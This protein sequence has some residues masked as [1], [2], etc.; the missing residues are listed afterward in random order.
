MGSDPQEAENDL[1]HSQGI[2]VSPTPWAYFP[3]IQ[4]PR[5]DALGNDVPPA[6]RALDK[7][8][9]PYLW[10]M[11]RADALGWF[12]PP[13]PQARCNPDEV[14]YES[15]GQVPSSDAMLQQGVEPWF[16]R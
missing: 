4:Q 13:A 9:R 8:A 14:V 3:F 11:G 2:P 10:V 15:W 7:V 16:P 12:L 5:A 1:D 6:P